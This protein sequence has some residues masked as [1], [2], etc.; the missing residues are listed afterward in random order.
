VNEAQFLQARAISYVE[1]LVLKTG[2]SS[3]KFKEAK[4]DSILSM[5]SVHGGDNYAEKINALTHAAKKSPYEFLQTVTKLDQVVIVEITHAIE[6][7]VI[8]FEGAT[9]EY[10]NNKKVLATVGTEFKS[11]DKKIEAL[12][13]L[14]KT[15][16]YA[17]AYQ[18]LKVAI[19]IAEEANLKK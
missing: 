3:F 5:L 17:Q 8:R 10:C 11:Q 16:E 2:K 19:E 6:L 15:P 9:A 14:L 1:T 18:E 7:S 4:I 12:A 13:D